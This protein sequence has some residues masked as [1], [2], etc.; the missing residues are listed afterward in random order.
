V[1]VSGRLAEI[2]QHPAV[3]VPPAQFGEAVA[4]AGSGAMREAA[5]QLDQARREC[6]RTTQALARIIGAARTQDRQF[7]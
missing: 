5:N 6:E 4:R 1:E 3:R 7:K 2:E